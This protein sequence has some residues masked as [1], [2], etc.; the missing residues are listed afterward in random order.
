MLKTSEQFA[1]YQL[2]AKETA[3]YPRENALAYLSSG[4]AGEVGELCSLIAKRFRQ[5]KEE[6]QVFLDEHKELV[7]G[8]LGDILWFVAQLSSLYGLTLS[9][10]VDY[11]VEK[12][13][14]RKAKGTLKGSGDHR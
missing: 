11:N 9:E 7:K 13:A 3:V 10:V 12:L 8:E 6:T 5:D 14:K 4:I 1:L 2:K